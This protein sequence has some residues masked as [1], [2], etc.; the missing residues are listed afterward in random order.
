MTAIT[1]HLNAD[2]DPYF[3]SEDLAR[4]FANSLTR[5]FSWRH[6]GKEV[7]MMGTGTRFFG[8]PSHD[9][10]HIIVI[11]PVDD[12][13]FPAPSNAVVYNSTGSIHRRLK[14][15]ELISDHAKEIRSENR[16][17]ENSDKR[18]NN[19]YCA[20]LD[21]GEIHTVITIGFDHDWT[22]DR[23]LNPETGEFGLCINSDKL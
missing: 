19:V 14:M 21:S 17:S 8:H 6:K 2:G 22:E 18:F 12:R 5:G 1:P 23:L 13:N 15:P 10:R 4:E 11:Y 9:M 3:Q 16:S 20:R 7:K